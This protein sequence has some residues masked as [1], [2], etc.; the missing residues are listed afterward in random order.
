[1]AKSSRAGFGALRGMVR[2]YKKPLKPP[3]EKRKKVLSV[4]PTNF[5]VIIGTKEMVTNYQDDAIGPMILDKLEDE[6]KEV[7]IENLEREF[8]AMKI[9]PVCRKRL[10]Y[11]INNS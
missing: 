4:S 6:G 9:S 3:A 11:I 5:N 8:Q 10:L 7:A 2:S 1:M